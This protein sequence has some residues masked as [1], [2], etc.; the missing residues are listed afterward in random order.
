MC[1]QA[2]S[3]SG[4]DLGSKSSCGTCQSPGQCPVVC[5][6][7]QARRRQQGRAQAAA[8]AATA[9]AVPTLRVGEPGPSCSSP[10]GRVCPCPGQRQAPVLLRAGQGWAVPGH[11]SGSD[12]P[13]QSHLRS[14]SV[15]HGLPAARLPGDCPGPPALSRG[16][17]S[18][19]DAPVRAWCSLCC[20]TGQGQLTAS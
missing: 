14:V 8:G 20:T 18:D 2:L 9:P 1:R 4:K 5:V 11:P 7:S 19:R 15:T 6:P 12:G 3:G 16:C 17:C 13:C 10:Q